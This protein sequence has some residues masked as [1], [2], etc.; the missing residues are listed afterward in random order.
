RYDI[1]NKYMLIMLFLKY[2]AMYIVLRLGAGIVGLTY[3]ILAS[4][5][6]DISVY[7]LLA[8][9]LIRGIK[10]YPHFSKN[11]IKEVFSYGIFSFTN[12]LIQQ[13]ALYIDKFILGV[14]YSTNAVAYLSA[15]KD[16]ITRASGLTGAVGRA[17]FPRFSSM[18]EGEDMQLL[19]TVSLWILTILSLAIFVPL[20][21][22]VPSFLAKWISPKFALESSDFAVLYSLGVA[23]NGG[24]TA[25]QALLKG[26]GRIKWLTQIISTLTVSSGIVT[27]ILV[28]KFGLV[29]AGIR[30]ILFSWI[31]IALCFYIGR[32]VF[33]SFQIGINIIQTVIIPVAI[34]AVFFFIAKFYFDYKPV[35]TWFEIIVS[36]LI[37]ITLMLLLQI[38]TNTCLFKKNGGAYYLLSRLKK[39]KGGSYRSIF[40]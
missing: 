13:A 33:A 3:L 25:Y 11:G 40:C 4:E 21:V 18:D 27:A 23:L 7:F 34:S 12:D 15:P 36:Y 37:L 20:A 19:Y 38:L 17:L 28:Y 2:I 9:F 31:G 35:K 5:I 32:K 39:I 14:F 26:T 1:L 24:V 10:C 30:V 16:L 8:K 6:V 29:G 22:I